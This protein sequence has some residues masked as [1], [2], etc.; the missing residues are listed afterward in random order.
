MI[1]SLKYTTKYTY[2]SRDVRTIQNRIICFTTFQN[3]S[4]YY[5]TEFTKPRAHGD[6]LRP[7]KKIELSVS[8]HFKT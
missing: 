1:I 7:Q 6:C 5:V 8:L 2:F 4:L 3:I